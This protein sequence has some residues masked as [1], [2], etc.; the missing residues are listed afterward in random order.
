[1][2]GIVV[3]NLAFVSLLIHPFRKLV[4]GGISQSCL[5][6]LG[7]NFAT[8]E[9]KVFRRLEWPPPISQELFNLLLFWSMAVVLSPGER[10]IVNL[11]NL[12]KTFFRFVPLRISRRH[13][14]PPFGV[15]Q[16]DCEKRAPT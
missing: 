9:T 10:G 8:K 13:D 7:I 4:I 14:K 3:T 5:P 15:G 11:G 2:A 16:F 6:C 1:M 12:P